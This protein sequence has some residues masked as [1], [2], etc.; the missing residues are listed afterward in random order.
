M[1]ST[2]IVE[3]TDCRFY[4]LGEC[5]YDYDS[6]KYR[7]N[8]VVTQSSAA[9]RLWTQGLCK[10]VSCDKRHGMLPLTKRHPLALH[11]LAAADAQPSLPAN[12]PHFT[13]PQLE[14]NSARN[15]ASVVSCVD[16]CS[17]AYFWDIENC[18]FS[19]ATNVFDLVSRIRSVCNEPQ[20]EAS[21][22]EVEFSCC[23]NMTILPAHVA[24]G[25]HDAGV[26]LIHV[27][28]PKESASDIALMNEIRR[29]TKLHQPNSSTIV[30]ITGDNDFASLINELRHRLQY[31][32]ILIHNRQA[33]ASLTK[34]PDISIKWEDLCNSSL[35]YHAITRTQSS[36]RTQSLL[37]HLAQLSTQQLQACSLCDSTF[38][39]M[40]D[41]NQH[42]YEVGHVENKQDWHR[43]VRYIVYGSDGDESD[44]ET[45][46]C[47]TC[48]IDMSS[49]RSLTSHMIVAQHGIVCQRCDR[50][51]DTDEALQQHCDAKGHLNAMHIQSYPTQAASNVSLSTDAGIDS[52]DATFGTDYQT[53]QLSQVTR[54]ASRQA[55]KSYEG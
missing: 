4:L 54:T 6:C 27:P 23:A 32:V 1:P 9:C 24:A 17:V 34:A 18:T 19:K 28:S 33:K 36:P 15:K 50:Q 55:V 38:S 39:T 43:I 21:P 25:L 12:S 46:E 26:K 10:D 48:S 35:D 40:S 3:L 14:A 22:T 8:K 51:F 30:L 20:H 29:F 5:K 44:V 52:V 16:E 49:L 11:Q 2:S 42:Q 47:P 45:F 41:L 37:V 13:I 7:H 31:K 53:A